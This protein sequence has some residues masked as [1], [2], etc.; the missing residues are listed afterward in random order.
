MSKPIFIIRFPYIKELD[1]E[2]FERY[3]KQIGEQLSD[4]HVLSL[5][6]S[7]VARV[8]FECFNAPHTEMEFEELKRRVLEIV[9]S[10]NDN[11]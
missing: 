9:E 10:P 5:I 1:R 8:E 4:Y 11:V 6:D 7:M 3:C 2:Q